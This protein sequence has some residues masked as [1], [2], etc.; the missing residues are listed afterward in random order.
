MKIEVRGFKKGYKEQM[1]KNAYEIIDNCN[2]WLEDKNLEYTSSE[3]RDWFKFE[4]DTIY[5]LL[6]I[7]NEE[8]LLKWVKKLVGK[9]FGNKEMGFMQG[10]RF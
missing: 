6:R 2:A 5:G 3:E 10:K 9:G 8:E 4:K 7:I 1:I